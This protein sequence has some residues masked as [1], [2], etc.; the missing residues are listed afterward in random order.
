LV[1]LNYDNNINTNKKRYLIVSVCIFI[2]LLVLFA[3]LIPISD[4]SKP[5]TVNVSYTVK[6]YVTHTRTLLS[7]NIQLESFTYKTLDFSLS[8]GQIVNIQWSSSNQI[9][10][11]SVM[12]QS[13]YDSFYQSL[14]LKVG[15]AAALAIITG[16]LIAPA[17]ATG[18]A[19]ALPDLLKSTG[20]IDYYSLNS[21]RD[22]YTMSLSPSLYK[23]VIF[24]F[25]N[26]GTAKINIS[27]N[28]QIL[29]DVIKLR[30]EIH[31][32]T[33]MVTLWQWIFLK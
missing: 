1:N 15:A 21:V 20:S 24:N 11:F 32:E 5:F 31:Y 27:Y 2:I 9:T 16:G 19:L 8:E 10:L 6:E 4:F 30:T 29:E 3:P 14:V 25:G 22:N 26:S 17:I 23:V 28:Y 33:K 12:K 13:T 18:F 7:D